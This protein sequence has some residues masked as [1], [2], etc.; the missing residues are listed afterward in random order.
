LKPAENPLPRL[1]SL[2]T[3]KAA[4]LYEV[5]RRLEGLRV[6]LGAARRRE[7]GWFGVSGGID[8]ERFWRAAKN[9]PPQINLLITQ[10]RLGLRWFKK[11]G[12]RRREGGWFGAR[13]G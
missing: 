13:G 10:R 6:V 1:S 2:I 5:L 8:Q 4:W 7:V 11:L 9:P 3:S 12:A